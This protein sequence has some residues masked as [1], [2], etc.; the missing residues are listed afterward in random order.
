MDFD[1]TK[2]K[3]NERGRCYLSD[4]ASDRRMCEVGV[5]DFAAKIHLPEPRCEGRS[6]SSAQCPGPPDGFSR[7]RRRAGL[8]F[9]FPSSLVLLQPP[10]PRPSE[11][12]LSFISSLFF[13]HVY[14]DYM[15]TMGYY[16]CTTHP[17]T[18][19]HPQPA[20]WPTTTTPTALRSSTTSTAWPIH[21]LHRLF[22][23]WSLSCS[24]LL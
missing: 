18:C 16:H 24:A 2:G 3:A 20:T 11:G 8:C 1:W 7:P 19:R 15:N 23:L 5:G 13:H 21:L 6:G 12:R 14:E 9:L 10:P 4:V 17:R 22:G